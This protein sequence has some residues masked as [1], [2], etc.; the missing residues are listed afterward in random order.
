MDTSWYLRY[1]AETN[2]D[3]GAKFG[4]AV[5][6]MNQPAVPVSDTETLPA[7]RQRPLQSQP[8]ILPSS[9]CKRSPTRGF[10][11]AM[12]EQGGS[13]LYTAMALKVTS[14]EVLR[15]VAC[16]HWRACCARIFAHRTSSFTL[17]VA[18]SGGGGVAC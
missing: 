15:I 1:R 18:S 2:P 4:Q 8:E 17:S 5:T 16:G 7:P 9:A 3:F 14:L 12:I 13:S 10:H 6:I 11:F